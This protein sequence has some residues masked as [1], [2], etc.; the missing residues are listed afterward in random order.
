MRDV[1]LSGADTPLH[2]AFMVGN[3]HFVKE[4]LDVM[5][6]FAKE[7]NRESPLHIATANGDV[8]IVKE[9]LKIDG[10]L[11]MVKGKDGRIPFHYAVIKG[12]HL[13]MKNNQFER[14]W[15]C[16]SRHTIKRVYWI[17]RMN[18]GKPSCILKSP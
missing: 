11:C 4:D 9:I 14:A 7:L 12:L 8:E 15:Q 3:L 13:A 17:R 5:L 1:A 6:K 10:S 16:T 2:I 18:R